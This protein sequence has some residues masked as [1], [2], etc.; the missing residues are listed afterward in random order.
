MGNIEVETDYSMVDGTQYHSGPPAAP[1]LLTLYQ[2]HG[3]STTTSEGG[4]V[5]GAIYMQLI[6]CIGEE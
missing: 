1:L 3:T 6:R 4:L 2:L 5:I